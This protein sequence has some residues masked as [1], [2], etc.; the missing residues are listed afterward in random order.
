MLVNRD[1]FNEIVVYC[2]NSPVGKRLP[3]AL[4]VHGCALSHL[5]I[6]LQDYERL[7]RL[8]D[9]VETATL[10]KFSTDQPKI[11]YLFYP[12][13]DSDPHPALTLSIVV[14]LTREKVSYWNYGDSDNPPILHRKETF[15][16][17]DYPKYQ[18]F[19]HLTR[20]EEAL[21]L[22]DNPRFIGTRNE[23]EK[24]LD[25]YRLSF[26][27]HTLI[28]PLPLH[29][30]PTLPV[31]IERH[32]AAIARKSLSRPVR[33]ALEADLFSSAD[34]TFFDYGCGY[35]GDKERLREQGYVCGGWDPYYCPNE[36]K[37]IAD[38]VNLG[39][40][41]N[42]IE[43]LQERRDALLQAWEL[44]RRVLIVSAQV[45]I[46]DSDRGV[47][48]YGD[49]IITRRNTFQKYYQ[50]EE[51]KSYIDQVL[52]TDAIPVGLGVYLVFRDSLQAESFR[53]SRFHSRA[54]TPRIRQTLQRYEDYEEILTPLIQFVTERG[55]LPRKGELAN[56]VQLK[57][58]FRSFR[59]AFQVILQVTNQ[60]D[61]D[62]IA[63]KRRQE[64]LLY[65]ALSHFTGRPSSRQLSPTLKEDI[66]S[67]FGSYQEACGLADM[68]LY[69]L[70]DMDTVAT[71]C[72]ESPV[73]K[74]L[75]NSLIVHISALDSLAPLL[76]LYEGCA[77][78]G[79]G[80]L[81]EANVVQFSFRHPKISYL[82][83]PD[84]DKN[85][86]PLLH[87]RMQIYLS[88]LE[89]RYQSYSENPNPP[90]LHEK[91]CLVNPDYPHYQKF[92]KLTEK[93]RDWGLLEDFKA[94]YRL[95]DWLTCLEEHCALIKGHSLYWRKD[96]D[97]YQ[98]KLLKSQ[99]A[100]RRSLRSH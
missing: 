89:V 61:W 64:L 37:T 23:W 87:T 8:T 75:K 68:M 48:A 79:V 95:K 80:R 38:V 72:H 94:I 29:P 27:G 24:R 32:K 33:L 81:E 30:N 17:P 62:A 52:N 25:H 96:G 9:E 67:L 50:Q 16:T 15:I 60:E 3:T 4:Y 55:R 91:D 86:H 40:V 65:L 84:F 5:V 12:D 63:Q 85:P 77:S 43:D 42:V 56:E 36:P 10:V 54:T 31:Q 26:V 58:E 6:P 41:I 49:G 53:L 59:R 35:G 28:C 20:I 21:G 90:I 100:A 18:D 92:Q 7:G 11:S 44:T 39:Y 2:Q 97:P 66:K 45:L 83:Y 14:D 74:L 82:Y 19:A 22:L 98:I 13:F 99:I 34:I 51:L 69:Q 93:E 73:G 1:R 57:A 78:R 46:N 88:N 76:R 70:R 71:L 47:V